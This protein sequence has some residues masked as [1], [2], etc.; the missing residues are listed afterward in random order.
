MSDATP[1]IADGESLRD[2]YGQPG[3]N[4]RAEDARPA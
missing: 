3:E 2:L 4:R 1:V